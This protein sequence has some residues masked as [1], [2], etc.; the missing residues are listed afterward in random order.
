MIVDFC[1]GGEK[2]RGREEVEVRGIRE[3]WEFG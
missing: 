2:G 1:D 3:M